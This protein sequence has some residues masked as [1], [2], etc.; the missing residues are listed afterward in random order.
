MSVKFAWDYTED[1]TFV[2]PA[3]PLGVVPAVFYLGFIFTEYGAQATTVTLNADWQPTTADP[4]PLISV[5]YLGA[6]NVQITLK[7][8]YYDTAYAYTPGSTASV[9]GIL[10]ITGTVNGQDTTNTLVIAF[11]GGGDY[12]DGVAAFGYGAGAPSNLWTNIR[13]A[14]E[15]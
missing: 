2:Q 3:V 5:T 13:Q 12:L 11:T 8:S 10:T 15:T 14:V 4:S 1:Y 6:G 9:R 7:R